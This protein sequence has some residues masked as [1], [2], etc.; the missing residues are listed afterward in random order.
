MVLQSWLPRLRTQWDPFAEMQVLERE[1]NRALKTFSGRAGR[2]GTLPEAAWTP[3]ADI[4]ETK[5]E[6]V[7]VLEL[8]GVNQKEVQI[9]LVGD[10]LSVR[11]ER[12]RAEEVEEDDCHRVE[13][14]FGPYFRALV[15][16]SVVDSSR[17]KAIYKDGLL[18][19]RLPKREEA[20]PRAIPVEG[21]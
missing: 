19:I 17:I 10:T 21:A 7:M 12:R 11:G 6:M 4:Y 15:L 18:E 14:R 20:K 3:P 8:P 5:D 16:P 9:S 2:T 13:R 1:M